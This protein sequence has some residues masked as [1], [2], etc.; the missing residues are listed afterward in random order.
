MSMGASQIL[1]SHYRSIPES[2]ISMGASQILGSRSIPEE[3]GCV[4]RCV[5][6]RRR[7]GWRVC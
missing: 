3:R 5:L 1:G 6:I 4:R 7:V 2:N